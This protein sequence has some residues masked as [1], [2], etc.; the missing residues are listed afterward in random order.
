M[1]FIRL[2]LNQMSQAQI[3]LD[4][5]DESYQID[6]AQ[7]PQQVPLGLSGRRIHLLAF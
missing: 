3:N 7:Q 4:E 5:F 6:L 2:A 1:P